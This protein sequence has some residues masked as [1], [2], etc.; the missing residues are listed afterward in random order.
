MAITKTKF[1]NIIRCPRYCALEE[2]K[3][4]EL[5]ADISYNDYKEEE[6][7]TVISEI[8][9][10]MVDD[11]GDSVIDTPDL[12]LE[13]LMPYYKKIELLAASQVKKQFQGNPISAI[14]TNKQES[15]DFEEDG[16]KYLCYVDIYNENKK[17]F[18]IIE[19]KATT[20]SKF[21]KL[22]PSSK[23]DF[24]NT[25]TNS[26]FIKK[27]DGIYYLKDEIENY[28]IEDDMTLDKYNQNKKK[29]FDK[30]NDCGHYVY[31]LL[32]QR[33]IIENDMKMH[34]NEDK[35]DNI[36][37]YLGVLNAEY[38]FDGT[39]LNNE[40]VYNTDESGNDIIVFF[41]FTKLTKELMP[42]IE[43]DRK[44]V[45]EYL[46]KMEASVCSLGIQCEFKKTTKCKYLEACFYQVV[47]HKNSILNYFKSNYGFEDENSS[48]YQTFDLINDG[49]V[50]M[51]DIPETWLT[52]PNNVIQRRVV[53]SNIEYI[54]KDKIKDGLKQLEYP[55][56][57]LD[58]ETFPCPIPRYKGEKC[59][60]QS[61][62]Q[63]SLHIETEP[64][65]CDKEKNHFEYLAKD[66]NDSR[67][68]LIKKLIE[69]I[70]I[71]KGTIIVY[72]ET[73]EKGRLKELA[74]LFPEYKTK[75]L[76]MRDMVFDLLFIVQNSSK[77]YLN[78]GYDKDTASTINYYHSKLNGS[79][80]IKK[81]LPIFA[82]E[83]SY[84]NLEVGNGNEAM[85][86]YASFPKLSKE[87]FN[88]QYLALLEYCKQDTWA[89]VIILD[90]LRN[91]V[92]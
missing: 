30:Y 73:F 28:K 19:V 50:N 75:L 35:I 78:L 67:E 83:L 76:K 6:K 22:G 81:V 37:Y 57:H 63:F 11:D 77:L 45:V 61:V 12:K 54:N 48:K 69:Y 72:N 53:D 21:L 74:N 56:Y 8:L 3:Q 2:I 86:T 68:E 66:H 84:D 80:S 55:L 49:K 24:G 65:I 17:A 62:F 39:Y 23:D 64:G 7:Q 52:R 79:F 91:L 15:F 29:L 90:K 25:T 43:I 33:M 4:N 71:D 92:K 60:T 14:E 26:I 38:I 47:P 58:F 18:D 51:L 40:P 10:T 34:N 1:I 5:D 13:M 85:V 46:K 44:R 32:V 27:E 36:K 42:K 87:D 41:D 89:M 9:V 70:N 82:P 31:D 59:Y 20:S 16:I 88:K